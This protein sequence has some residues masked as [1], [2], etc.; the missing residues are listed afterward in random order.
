MKLIIVRARR[1][2]NYIL[3]HKKAPLKGLKNDGGVG[4]FLRLPFHLAMA[5][6]RF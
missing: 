2:V 3:G 4:Y 6:P 1:R 5:K